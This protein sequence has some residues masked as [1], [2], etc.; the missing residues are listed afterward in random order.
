V[1]FVFQWMLDLAF[2]FQAGFPLRSDLVFVLMAE[3][4]ALRDEVARCKAKVASY[5]SVKR[6][7]DRL[8]RSPSRAWLPGGQGTS[9]N[10]PC[11]SPSWIYRR[12]S[13]KNDAFKLGIFELKRS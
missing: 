11:E 12:K 5:P 2:P 1:E 9:V 3:N 6:Q 4:A 10:R 8:S 13:Q 7:Y